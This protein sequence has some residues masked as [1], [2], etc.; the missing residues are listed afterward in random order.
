MKKTQFL[1]HLNNESNHRVLL[2]EA[3]KLTDGLV[4]EFGSGHG[5]TPFLREY[6][7]KEQREFE[8]FENN[9]EWAKLTGSNLV[10]D[11]NDIP[12]KNADVLFIDHAPGERRK[13]DLFIYRNTAKIIVIHDTEKAADHGYQCRQHFSKFKWGAEINTPEGGA[14]AAIL[15]NHFDLSHLIG[16]KSGGF[17]IEGLK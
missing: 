3:L 7:E 9:K 6:C 5:S 4:V 2:W 12:I 14:G 16:M 15:S 10:A 13:H 1:K 11:W 8:S 17:N